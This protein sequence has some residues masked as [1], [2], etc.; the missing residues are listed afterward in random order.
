MSIRVRT[1]DALRPSP[2]TYDSASG[3]LTDEDGTLHVVGPQGK[4]N[5]A[6]YPRGAW[7]AV[8]RVEVKPALTH[9]VTGTI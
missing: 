7:T 9:D 4:G 1:N 8:L 2:D 3:W 6:S 5:L